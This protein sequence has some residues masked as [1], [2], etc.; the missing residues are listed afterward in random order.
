M[1]DRSRTRFHDKNWQLQISPV[2][3]FTQLLLKLRLGLAGNI[4]SFAEIANLEKKISFIVCIQFIFMFL[5][6]LNVHL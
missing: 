2:S 1:F 5:N 4:N 3:K 6:E